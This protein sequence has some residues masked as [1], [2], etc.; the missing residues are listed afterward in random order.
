M[1]YIRMWA[2]C[3]YDLVRSPPTYRREGAIAEE[4]YRRDKFEAC[5]GDDAKSCNEFAGNVARR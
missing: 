3:R 2:G 5:V 1:S 4:G